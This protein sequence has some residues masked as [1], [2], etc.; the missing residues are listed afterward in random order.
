MPHSTPVPAEIVR[1]WQEIVDQAVT[2]MLQQALDC[3][4]DLPT[5]LQKA[6]ATIQDM[7]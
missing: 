6:K 5:L 3:K 4:S 2:P 7:M 1:K